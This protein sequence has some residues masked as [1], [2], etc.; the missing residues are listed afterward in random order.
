[1]EFSQREVG[2][3]QHRKL[4]I[5]CREEEVSHRAARLKKIHN[6]EMQLE[7]K[8][9]CHA[10]WSGHRSRHHTLVLTHDQSG[11]DLLI[12]TMLLNA[13]ETENI[14]QQFFTTRTTDTRLNSNSSKFQ[15]EERGSF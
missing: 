12:S 7:C 8:I 6:D 13:T 11:M 2:S 1:M 9:F 10:N 15:I 5:R 14:Y 4:H 3:T